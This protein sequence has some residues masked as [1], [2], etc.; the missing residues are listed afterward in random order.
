M[1][2]QGA[3]AARFIADPHAS[4]FLEPFMGGERTASAVAAE[5][6]VQVSS[7]L[8]RTQ[9]MLE[10]GLLRVARTEPRRGRPVKYYRA[11]ADSFFVPFELTD[12]ETLGALGSSSALELRQLLEASLGAAHEALGRT[13]GGVGVRLVRDQEGRIDRTL[14]REAA[15]AEA[16]SF[17]E[18]TLDS[19]APA[20]WDQHCTLDLTEAEAK[21]LQRELSEVFGRY[22]HRDT[23]DRRPYILRLALAPAKR[24]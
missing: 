20:L 2:V 8:Y 21:A 17:L 4:R 22:Y 15:S 11:V 3:R 14:T 10:L 19:R 24:D 18:L 1:V 23:T 9:Q 13:F 12:A 7:V 6:G 16:A 5:L